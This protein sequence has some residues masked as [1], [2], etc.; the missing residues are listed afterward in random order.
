MP[1]YWMLSLWYWA[2]TFGSSMFS[3]RLRNFFKRLDENVR[4]GVKLLN[5]CFSTAKWMQFK[6]EI[7]LET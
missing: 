3:G 7:I 6:L 1:Q 4:W 2:E 5:T